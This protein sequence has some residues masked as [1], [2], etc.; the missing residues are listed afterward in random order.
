MKTIKIILTLLFLNSILNT[1]ELRNEI[2]ER[3]ELDQALYECD[4]SVV[5][6]LMK[7]NQANSRFDSL[8]VVNLKQLNKANK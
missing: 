8:V 6:N 5:V 2:H 3:K 4:S 7:L 1:Y